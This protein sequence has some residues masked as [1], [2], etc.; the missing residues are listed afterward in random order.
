MGKIFYG[1]FTVVMAI[2]V[3]L[4]FCTPYL[5]LAGDSLSDWIYNPGFSWA[6]H[7]KISRSLCLFKDG[8]GSYFIADCMKQAGSY[9]QND[10]RIIK[11]TDEHGNIGYKMP[12]CS[13]DIAI[14]A[15]VLLASLIYPFFRKLGSDEVPS[16]VYLLLALMPMAVDGGLQLL[17]ELGIGIFGSYESTNMARIVT[18]A[19]GGF[20]LP[21]YIFPL[22]DHYNSGRPG[23]GKK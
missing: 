14:Y 10:N 6:C 21:F 13:R 16:A 19:I 20:A 23:R 11:A 7:Q 8:G 18:G 5:A 22:W 12:V 4:I 9:V 2:V 17:S 1:L 3:F 15:A